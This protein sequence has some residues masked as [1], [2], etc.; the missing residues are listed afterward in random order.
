ML[1]YWLKTI[2][3]SWASCSD[4][5]NGIHVF[6]RWVPDLLLGFC[7]QMLRVGRPLPF[8]CVWGN[9]VATPTPIG[10]TVCSKGNAFD[11]SSP[12]VGCHVVPNFSHDKPNVDCLQTSLNQSF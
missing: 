10:R 11:Q 7:A 5:A 4:A 1:A 8:V 6:I 2:A 12:T 3:V 9:N